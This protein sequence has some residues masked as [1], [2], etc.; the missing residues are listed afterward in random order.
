MTWPRPLVNAGD[1][2]PAALGMSVAAAPPSRS[3]PPADACAWHRP[4]KYCCCG[5]RQCLSR[6]ASHGSLARRCGRGTQPGAGA[7]EAETSLAPT[8]AMPAALASL[9]LTALTSLNTC[10]GAVGA[11]RAPRH[12][13]S[14]LRP[15][16]QLPNQCHSKGFLQLTRALSAGERV[17]TRCWLPASS[18]APLLRGQGSTQHHA[19]I[20][21]PWGT[22]AGAGGAP[23]QRNGPPPRAVLCHSGT[24]SCAACASDT[25]QSR[26]APQPTC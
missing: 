16:A 13:A 12:H 7:G 23:G 19:P 11:G 14:L 1:G 10:V 25:R 22:G 6:G 3:A 8:S 15:A 2:A 21:L 17:H 18:A 26:P 9:P 4:C 5:V 24:A 20:L